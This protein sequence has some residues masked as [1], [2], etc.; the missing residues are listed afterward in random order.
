MKLFRF[1]LKWLAG[2]LKSPESN[3]T[4]RQISI[5]PSKESAKLLMAKDVI[6]DYI[7]FPYA[8]VELTM[9]KGEKKIFD[10]L[11]RQERRKMAQRFKTA[12]RKG[13]IRLITIEGKTIALK[14]KN[15]GTDKRTNKKDPS[16][17]KHGFDKIGPHPRR[18]Q[19]KDR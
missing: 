17:G 18:N 13:R 15:Y 14:N 16:P 6:D 4:Q 12:V 2:L 5:T 1:I 11:P 7:S 9:R 19:T 10:K 8:G 3:I